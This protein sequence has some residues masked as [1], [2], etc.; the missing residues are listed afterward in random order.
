MIVVPAW[1]RGFKISHH[2]YYIVKKEF[3]LKLNH[4]PD[5]K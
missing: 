1:G 2:D 4:K 3:L 5:Y